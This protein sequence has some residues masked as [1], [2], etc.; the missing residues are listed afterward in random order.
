M[1]IEL[2]GLP[3]SGKTTFAKQLAKDTDIRIVK[4]KNKFEL[5]I[6]NIFFT[7]RH[8]VKCIGLLYYVTRY[9]HRAIFRN[10]FINLFLHH[11]AKYI[12]SYFIKQAIIDQGHFQNIISLFEHEA[13][14]NI[15]TAYS[16]FFIKA[17]IL[18]VFNHP[19]EIRR[20]RLA[21]RGY[22]SREDISG[23]T[24]TQWMRASFE[25]HR[26]F[27]DILHICNIPYITIENEETE[28]S[29]FERIRDKKVCRIQYIF[30]GRMPTEKAH[31]LQIAHMCA[32]FADVGCAVSLHITHRSNLLEEDIFNFYGVK[33]NFSVTEYKYFDFMKI[34][35]GTRIGFRIESFLW[36]TYWIFK[37]KKRDI[38]YYTRNEEVSFAIGLCGR[39]IVFEAHNVTQNIWKQKVLKLFL[40]KTY[41]IVCNSIGTEKAIKHIGLTQTCVATNGVSFD[42]FDLNVSKEESRSKLSL[43]QKKKIVMYVGKFYAWKGTEFLLE[44]W[45]T[46]YRENQEAVLYMVGGSEDEI[47]IYKKKYNLS[48]IYYVSS[49]KHSR[50]PYFLKA[51]DVLVLP[52]IAH[53]KESVHFTSPIKIYE[54]MASGT[55]VVAADLPSIQNLANSEEVFFFKHGNLENL[56]Q[57]IDCVLADTGEVKRRII[58]ARN[59][60][61][62]NTWKKRAEKIKKKIFDEKV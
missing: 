38:V 50:I 15:I 9:G 42:N 43:L 54:Y 8:P 35:L 46:Y 37:N 13:D 62:E 18:V 4:I 27:M 47:E 17:D 33:K 45:S 41:L 3:G 28:K 59:R 12:K 25:N 20:R 55:P 57:S 56:K 7:I 31:G 30:R 49:Q 48:N 61:H 1:I 11:N 2:Y 6:Y 52:N 36:A 21:Q 26:V 51:A 34:L 23:Y 22:G 32:S 19:E 14:I 39:R 29:V 5:I 58:N 16:R 24:N 10:K 40:W 60:A 44:T 53:T